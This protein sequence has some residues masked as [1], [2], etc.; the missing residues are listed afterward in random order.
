MSVTREWLRIK[1]IPE[2]AGVSERTVR[3]WL[4][5]GL[6]HSRLPSGMILIRRLAL[7]DFLEQFAGQEQEVDRVVGEIMSDL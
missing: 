2:Y 3:E 5:R 1:D 4:K 6:R 7:D